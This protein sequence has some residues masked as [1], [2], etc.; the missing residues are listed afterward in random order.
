ME[1]RSAEKVCGEAA[2][3]RATTALICIEEST[4]LAA[5]ILT[6]HDVHSKKNRIIYYDNFLRNGIFTTITLSEM[7]Y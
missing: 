5:Y 3:E 2:L 7:E 4:N 6:F 1:K